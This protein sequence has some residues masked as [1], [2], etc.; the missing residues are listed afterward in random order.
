MEKLG[1]YMA[2]DRGVGVGGQGLDFTFIG[3]SWVGSGENECQVQPVFFFQ[4][5]SCCD[6]SLL[7]RD[8]AISGTGQI[9]SMM[10]QIG[11][12]RSQAD[13]LNHQH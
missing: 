5:F 2:G 7:P 12:V 1:N 4:D 11:P 13:I 9:L 3:T 10:R 6:I 8:T